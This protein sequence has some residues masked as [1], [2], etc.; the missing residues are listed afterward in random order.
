[1][2]FAS[3]NPFRRAVSPTPPQPDYDSTRPRMT[4]N[5]FLDP[6]SKPT[7]ASKPS[8]TN[9]FDQDI[10]VSTPRLPPFT[11]GSCNKL[12]AQPPQVTIFV[13]MCADYYSQ[14]DLSL[15]DRPI[16]SEFR[17]SFLHMTAGQLLNMASDENRPTRVGTTPSG[18]HRPSRSDEKDAP[19]QR[20]QDSRGL[21]RTRPPPNGLDIFASPQKPDSRRPRRNSE[22]SIMDKDKSAEDERRRR[23]RRKEREARREKEGRSKDGKSSSSSKPQRKPQGL[24]I[25]DKLDVTGIYGQGREFTLLPALCV[26]HALTS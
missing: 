20:Q 18:T 13:R 23:E 19:R 26:T 14:K 9:P 6:P 8:S 5:P 21:P 11:C 10:F 24:D 3:N 7:L 16:S 4:N 17:Q 2:N 25:I 12:V 15:L 1:M 22:S